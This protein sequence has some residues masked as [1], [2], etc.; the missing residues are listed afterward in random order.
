MGD[1]VDRKLAKTN[2]KQKFDWAHQRSKVYNGIG[3]TKVQT[4]GKRR[5]LATWLLTRSKKILPGYLESH[6]QDG[7]RPMLMSDESQAKMGF[8]KDM[9]E[10]K[11]YLK[12]YDD[13]IDVYRAE[14]SGLKVVCISH[15]PK[16]AMKKSDSYRNRSATNVACR[17]IHVLCR[18][19]Q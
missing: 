16:G 5:L 2:L 1:D 11:I 12:D 8:V 6:E 15:S 4:Y 18:I 7:R 10:G 9:R 14:G 19:L 13:Y 17:L 3:G